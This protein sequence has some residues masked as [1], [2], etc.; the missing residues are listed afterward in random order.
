MKASDR[1]D[2]IEHYHRED[3]ALL[4]SKGHDYAGNDDA[5]ANLNRFGAFGIIVRLSDKFSR[6]E[7]FA[8]SGL[9]LVQTEG[10]IDICRD[11]RVY[12]YLLQIYLE[13]KDK[14]PSMPLFQDEPTGEEGA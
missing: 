1:N 6:L 5:L 12:A 9:L 7:Q 2:I 3:M 10:P 11:V 14:D 4:K 13:G 8:K